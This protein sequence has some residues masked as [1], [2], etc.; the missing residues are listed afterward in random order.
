M[1]EYDQ[2]YGIEDE[3]EQQFADEL[4]VMAEI[5]YEPPRQTKVS[6]FRNQKPLSFEDAIASGDLI[7]RK[8]GAVGL[9]GS[10]AS[11]Q[12]TVP[13]PASPLPAAQN[14]SELP[15][16]LLDSDALHSPKSKRPRQD[17]AK[18]LQFGLSDGGHDITP[19]SSPEDY[20]RS[21]SNSVQAVPASTLDMSGLGEL[22]TSPRRS[23]AAA[24]HVLRR[25][26]ASGDY[27]S[28]TDSSGNRVYL[29]KKE[30]STM[31]AA[32]SRALRNSHYSLG[33]LSVPIEV[34]M[35]QVA[36]KRHRQVVEE[37]QRLSEML[38]SHIDQEFGELDGGEPEEDQ[39]DED[40][41]G[42]ASRLW[43]DRFSP[44]HY[45]ELLSDDFTNRCLLKWLKLWDTV[46]F[47]REKTAKK[48][49]PPPPDNKLSF[50]QKDQQN[51]RFKTKTQITEEILEA[52]LD[53]YQ[54][55]KYKVALLSGPPGLGKTTLAHIIARHA[56]YNVVEMNASDDRSAELF[57][58][59]IDTAT[60]M[61][62]VLGANEK[63]NC[64]VIDEI[65]GAPTAAINVLLANLNRKESRE[66]DSETAGIA[67]LK[68]KK[69]KT[70]S[71][72][73]RPIIC[74]CNDLY[75]PA[76]R[77]LRQQAFILTFPPTQPSRL[78]QRLAEISRC[79]DMKVDTGALMALCE[80]TDNDIRSCINTLQF[81]HGRG[82]RQLDQRLVQSM[83]I[84]QK[85]QNKGLF[86]VW[87][88][89]FQLPRVKRK[90][91]GE[92]LFTGMDHGVQ[93]NTTAHRLQ[94]ILLL[95]SSSGEHE[96]LAQGLY[97]NFLSMKLKDPSLRGVCLA[98]EW[99]GFS[100]ILGETMM[101]GQNFSLMRYL[102][103]LPAAFHLLFAATSI[104]RISYPNSQ[105]EALTRTQHTKNVLVAMLAEIHPSIRSRV[106]VLC[107]SLDILGL[108]LEV[109]CPK[110]RPVNP[111][112][113]STREKQQLVE[114]VD[115][116]LS[117]NLTYRQDRS[118][119]GQYM[120]LLEPN[121]EEAARFP[122]L[123]PRR[124][125]TYQAKQMIAREIEMERMRRAEALLQA[126]N[127]RRKEEE[128]EKNPVPHSG[129][130]KPAARNH[131]QRLENIVKQTVVEIR[132]EVDFFG[133]TVVPKEKP[134]STAAPGE[135]GPV[136]VELRMGKAVGNSEVWFRFNEGVSNAVRRNVYI[137][138][139]L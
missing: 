62:S 72:L 22:Q 43:V 35:E 122:G 119:E 66:A 92:D 83:T 29:A 126:R 58:K 28:V 130:L 101:H 34:L 76:L 27:I 20:S 7:L 116:M 96:K 33:L 10:S 86:S 98:L 14:G 38:N 73:L 52:E 133:R 93:A 95:V 106:G 129:S 78:V 21:A 45:T 8:H 94:H 4:E 100:D 99:L 138:D 87:Q 64:L 1:D 74:I 13:K 77:Q 71:V 102:P 5:D 57:Q 49:K 112:L 37:S 81:L 111:Q 32:D 117:Y 125:L 108:L 12:N 42:T 31:S 82:Q 136:S 89:I 15:E 2:M 59:R 41:N 48:P 68:K 54:R 39:E 26:P 50:Q 104:P 19:P 97:D 11:Q 132:P 90:R 115:T 51:S 69:K 23:Y 107:L 105:Y 36:E 118:P 80:K 137:K 24:A 91:V 131:Q 53:Q 17:V 120:Y 128:K 44:R 47:G 3:F 114:L 135:E 84:G 16:Y 25:P 139:L 46:V 113:Y 67:A 63:P 79:Q 134:V 6:E 9:P 88:E 55:P 30:E 123:P 60:Q 121:V 103:F 124:Q 70:Q 75:V 110:L 85:D 61:K 40:Q 127:P 56:G 18:K 109:I 65:D